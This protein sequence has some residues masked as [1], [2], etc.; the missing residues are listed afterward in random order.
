[1]PESDSNLA[2]TDLPTPNYLAEAWAIL[3]R[4]TLLLPTLE[5]LRALAEEIRRMRQ[6]RKDL[7]TQ[8]IAEE[9]D[10]LVQTQ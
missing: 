5:H 8:L 10:D 9:Q 7:I 6:H 4:E 3:H 2:T 1:M